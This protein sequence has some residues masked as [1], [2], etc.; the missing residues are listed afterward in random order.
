MLTPQVVA[1]IHASPGNLLVTE[2]TAVVHNHDA[3]PPIV[4]KIFVFLHEM[5]L[6]DMSPEAGAE[7]LVTDETGPLTFVVVRIQL[8]VFL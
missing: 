8:N 6:V 4:L 1:Y 2:Q 3:L 5:S 7:D